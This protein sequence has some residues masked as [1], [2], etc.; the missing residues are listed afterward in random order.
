MIQTVSVVSRPLSALLTALLLALVG[1]GC[2]PSFQVIYEGDARFEHCY[3]LDDSPNV[4]MQEKTDCWSQWL[5]HY[6]YGQTRDRADYAAMRAAA[7]QE[8]HALPTDE[9]V[10]GAAPGGGLGSSR[11]NEPAPTSAFTVPPKTMNEVDAGQQVLPTMPTVEV[12]QGTFTA[13]APPAP[14]EECTA[15]CKTSWQ[16]CKTPCKGPTCAKC[17][18]AYGTCVKGCF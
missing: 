3:A 2:G 7:L 17:D 4:S 8:V 5:Q 14:G 1:G 9:A 16:G 15:N 18:K 13:A 11:I 12:S 10:M 6:T